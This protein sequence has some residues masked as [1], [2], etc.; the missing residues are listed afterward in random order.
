MNIRLLKE[1]QHVH[2]KEEL[3]TEEAWKYLLSLNSFEPNV[4]GCLRSSQGVAYFHGNKEIENEGGDAGNGEKEASEY[5]QLKR[6]HLS[7]ITL[8]YMCS[9]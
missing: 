7:A 6:A 9:H 8:M 2:R 1:R 3:T 5:N 4:L